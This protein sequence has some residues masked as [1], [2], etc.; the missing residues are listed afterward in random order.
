MLA[1]CTVRCQLGR[2]AVSG[3]HGW[4]GRGRSPGKVGLRGWTILPPRSDRNRRGDFG[5][6][7]DF[8]TNN[9]LIFMPYLPRLHLA[10][11][12]HRTRLVAELWPAIL[13]PEV[14]WNTIFAGV[15]AG[16]AS[17]ASQAL[18]A[19]EAFHPTIVGG[20]RVVIRTGAADTTLLRSNSKRADMA[21][22]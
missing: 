7:R 19:G 1:S 18:R 9:A 5:R 21:F 17:R 15:M 4:L 3:T 20:S 16:T 22:G 14:L 6:L 13:D 2:L 11:D 10:A 8:P 12:A